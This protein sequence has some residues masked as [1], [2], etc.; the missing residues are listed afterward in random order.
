M[1]KE[2]HYH[3]TSASGCVRITPLPTGLAIAEAA[4]ILANTCEQTYMSKTG[5]TIAY[6]GDIRKSQPLLINRAN[7][8]VQKQVNGRNGRK[9]ACPY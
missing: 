8:V 9:M 5:L 1:R 2:K 4:G 7:A 6:L 3:L